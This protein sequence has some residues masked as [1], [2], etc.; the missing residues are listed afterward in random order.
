VG[1]PRKYAT[2][3]ERREAKR[4]AFRKWRIAHREAEIL[5]QAAYRESHR[6]AIKLQR[7]ESRKRKREAMKAERVER[8]IHPVA[9]KS[10]P[11]P[12]AGATRRGQC[13]RRWRRPGGDCGTHPQA[14][15]LH[16]QNT[17][18]TGGAL[19][20]DPRSTTPRKSAAKPHARGSESTTTPTARPSTRS[21]RSAIGRS[22]RP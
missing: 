8:M 17:G 19:C 10:E 14:V 12:G 13:R 2:D 6:E 21:T 9:S 7:A 16:H 20:P 15:V 18:N 11:H 4:Q 5:R 3:E 22:V 1:G